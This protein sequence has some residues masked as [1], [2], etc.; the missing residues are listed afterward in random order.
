MSH[1]QFHD[2]A[3]RTWEVW[4]VVPDRPERRRDPNAASTPKV[5]RERRRRNEYRD[6]R[7]G[8]LA[9]GWLCFETGTEKRRL[10]PVPTDWS[11]MSDEQLDELCNEA[12]P[13]RSKP[14]RLLE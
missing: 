9:S 6:P 2:K 4:D 11:S 1:R 12:Q 13:S 5:R 10:A 14:R 8:K 3:G 7:T